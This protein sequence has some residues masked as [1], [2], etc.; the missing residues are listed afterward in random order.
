MT[1]PKERD[2]GIHFVLNQL[3]SYKE[4]S[5][6]NHIFIKLAIDL[7]KLKDFNEMMIYI[8]KYTKQIFTCQ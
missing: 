5:E 3:T 4:F 7:I 1:N 8:N 6:S 2:E